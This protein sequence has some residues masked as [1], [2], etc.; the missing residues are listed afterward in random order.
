MRS[1]YNINFDVEEEYYM[2]GPVGAKVV[3]T[4]P[5]QCHGDVAFVVKEEQSLAKV[6]NEEAQGECFLSAHRPGIVFRLLS[7]TTQTVGLSLTFQMQEAQSRRKRCAPVDGRG[8]Q[9]SHRP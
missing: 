7:A 9:P 8:Q 1:G 4:S 5:V 6:K 3:T 2:D